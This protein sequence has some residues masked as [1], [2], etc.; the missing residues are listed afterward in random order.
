MAPWR[1]IYFRTEVPVE[2]KFRIVIFSSV[3]PSRLRHFL[4]RLVT[5]L[6]EVEVAGMLYETSRPPLP[7]SK[8]LSRLSGL[9]QDREFRAFAFHKL[10]GQFR[11]RV[12]N[13][14]DRLLRLIHACPESPN[15][16]PISLDSLTEYCKA[17]GIAFR[18]TSDFHA[19]ESLDFVRAVAPH[20]GVIFG[21][22]ILKPQLFAIPSRG[23]INIHKH[24]VPDYR[25]SGAPGIWEM[26]DGRDEATVTVHRVLASVDAGAVLGERTFR[27]DPFDTLVSVGLKADVLAIDLLVD[28]LRSESRGCS[29]EVPQT[30]EGTVYKGFKDHQLFAI[31]RS[32]RAKR[33]TYKSSRGRPAHKLIMRTLAYPALLFR[34]L[35][36]RRRKNFPVIILFHHLITDKPKTL[37]LPTDHFLKHIRFLKKHYRIASLPEAV[38]MLKRNEVPVPTV[39]LTFDDGYAENFL[40]LRAVIE[41]ENVPVAL[42]VC[43]QAVSDGSEFDH[44]LNRNEHGFPALTWDQVRYFDRHDV[45]IGSHTRNHFD[46]G[47]GDVQALTAEIAGSHEDLRRELGHDVLFFSFPKGMEENM[48]EAAVQLAGQHYPYVFSAIH[49]ANCGSLAPGCR[50]YR[51]AYPASIW[52]VELLLQSLLEFGAAVPL[53]VSERN[54]GISTLALGNVFMPTRQGAAASTVPP[55]GELRAEP[56]R[57]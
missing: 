34:N 18:V 30:S 36:R 46:C 37:G 25:G 21:T 38:E 51:C 56:H 55:A 8:R 47:S 9:V 10:V 13:S 45:T 32:I 24:K 29:V 40:G 49:G 6:P 57:E 42:F 7:L 48:S 17:N 33:T 11:S 14:F 54:P 22:R 52:E 4:W 44:D 41:A 19:Q 27:I 15:G 20:L 23:S 1:E 5:D 2:P 3:P 43:T 53:D 31:E 28:V 50:F 12:S 35:H 16:P 39:V 26:R